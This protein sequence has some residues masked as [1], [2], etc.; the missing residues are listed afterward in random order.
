MVMSQSISATYRLRPGS[1]QPESG[2]PHRPARY[3]FPSIVDA[4]AGWDTIWLGQTGAGK[5][6]GVAPSETGHALGRAG[7]AGRQ[8]FH[9]LVVGLRDQTWAHPLG[10]RSCAAHGIDGGSWHQN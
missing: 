7:G 6:L 8:P 5:F 2:S 4:V 9:G 3:D 10:K 1:R